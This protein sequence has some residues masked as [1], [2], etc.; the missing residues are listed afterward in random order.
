M[1]APPSAQSVAEILAEKAVTLRPE[2]IPPA[3]RERAEQ[4]LLDVVGLCVAARNT[5]YLKALVAAVDTG[6]GCTAIGRAAAYDAGTAG[7]LNGPAAHG[8]DF[9]DTFEGGPVHS[10]AVVIPAVLAACERFGRDGRAAL[11]GI[12]AGVEATCRLSM[13]IPKAIHQA[14]FHPT[15]VLG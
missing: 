9:D 4:L 5:D 14:G 10:S 13:I 15:S 7:L 3:V 2:V 1:N 11:T 8:E 6:G 12:V